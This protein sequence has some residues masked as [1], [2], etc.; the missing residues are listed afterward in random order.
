[1]AFGKFKD[2]YI[3]VPFCNGKCSYCAFYS[4]PKVDPF[5]V[6]LWLEKLGRDLE[7][8][9]FRIEDLKT[10]YIG[11]GTPTALSAQDL[12]RLFE[13]LRRK[14]NFEFDAEIS[15]E[16][17][18]GS[19]DKT[20]AQLLASFV[21]RVSVGA[22]SF[23]EELLSTIGRRGTNSFS[24]VERTFEEL[25]SAGI[26]NL[27]LDMIYAIPGETPD[28]WRRELETALRLRPE[29]ISAYAL[30]VE[31]G[32]ALSHG[33]ALPPDDDLA[34]EMWE[35]A[36]EILY[37]AG[38]PRYEVSNYASGDFQCRHNQAVWHGSRYLGIGPSASS[39]DGA[40][41]WTEVPNIDFWLSGADPEFDDLPP[42]PRAKELFIM[43]LRTAKGWKASE[44]KTAS[45]YDFSVFDAKLKPMAEEGLLV[46]GEESV[47][48][49]SKGLAFW[50]TMAEELL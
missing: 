36:G 16:C 50:N 17:N 27:G 31:E 19:L 22:Q 48:P 13:L 42:L 39:F 46:L 47:K 8:S 5:K 12:A 21:N 45:G 38:L 43:G 23:D 11:G 9:E 40:R 29:H 14:L 28:A 1:M 7:R 26:R 30:T 2:L 18:P 10:L 25:R 24:N 37:D 32:T 33:S 49:T 44:F 4:E 15:I 34:A 20:K 6:S 3:H 35:I 41:R